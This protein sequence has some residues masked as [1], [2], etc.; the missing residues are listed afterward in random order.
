VFPP[1]AG[2]PGGGAGRRRRELAR[3]VAAQA[4][5]GRICLTSW[6]MAAAQSGMCAE[7][8]TR[9]VER[10]QA[11]HLDDSPLGSRVNLRCGLWERGEG[12]S[13]AKGHVGHALT[14]QA[15]RR[16]PN[17][18]GR[19][20]RPMTTRTSCMRLVRPEGAAHGVVSAEAPPPLEVLFG[21][22]MPCP[23]GRIHPASSTPAAST[24]NRRRMARTSSRV[25]TFRPVPSLSTFAAPTAFA[26]VPIAASGILR[27]HA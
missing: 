6:V 17:E 25:G 16:A 8:C 23:R 14:V 12:A 22:G 19:R 20:R 7:C 3:A 10:G 26:S 11:P 21:H 24:P 27:S 4:G 18:G 15:L 2:A 9:R 1:P 5:T 13:S